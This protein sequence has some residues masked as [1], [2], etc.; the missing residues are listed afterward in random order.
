MRDYEGIGIPVGPTRKK[1]KAK[2]QRAETKV[3]TSVRAECVERDGVCR[4]FGQSLALYELVGSCYGAP[5]WAHLGEKRRA[6][7]RGMA[8]D[9]RHT[10]ADS[11]MLCTRHHQAYDA[12]TFDIMGS[13]RGA[14]ATLVI[15]TETGDYVEQGR[16]PWGP[17]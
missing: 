13:A 5:E 17:S 9:V 1:V 15:H 10:T 6:H 3:K 12:R 2:K 14:N 11:L 8:P 4:L 7:T 16:W